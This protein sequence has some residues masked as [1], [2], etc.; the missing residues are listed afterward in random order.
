MGGA[1]WLCRGTWEQPGKGCP[2]PRLLVHGPLGLCS[3]GEDP[4]ILPDPTGEAG[5]LARAV[6]VCLLLRHVPNLLWLPA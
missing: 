1:C 4:G 3:P 2:S 5:V 6:G